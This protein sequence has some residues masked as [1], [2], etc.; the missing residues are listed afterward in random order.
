[1]FR[2]AEIIWTSFKMA[3]QE[4]RSN[5]LRTFLSL[6]GIT[7]GIFCII[8][9]LSTI[10]SMQSAV[11]RDLSS[12][13]SQTIFVDKWQIGLG[14]DYP[15]WKYIKRPVPKYDELK[16]LKLKVPEAPHIAYFTSINANVDYEE[17]T[18]TGVNYYGCSEDFNKIQTIEIAQGRYFEQSEFDHG[19]PVIVM[20]Y[21]IAEKL[22]GKPENCIGVQVRLKGGKTATIIGMIKKQGQ[23]M[24]GGWDYDNCVMLPH[25]FMK[26]IVR[27]DYAS[28]VMLVEAG[29]G[30]SKEA[31]KD[32]LEGAMRSIRKLSPMQEDNFALNDIDTLTKFLEPIFRGM[33]IGG[34]VIAAL[35]L[36]VGMFGVANIM[37]VTVRERTSQ[38]GLKKAIGAKRGV[39][40]TEFLLESAFLCIIGGIFGLAAVFVLT[41][42]ISTSI[43]F[44]VT[45]PAHIILLAV[46]ICIGTGVIAGIIPAFIAARMDPVVAIRTK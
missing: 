33:N 18:L 6:L 41:L 29:K 44:P 3:L 7:F 4:F 19:T 16:A 9:V 42:I 34:W 45:I 31:L 1:M 46:S 27:D 22:F 37:F 40:L 10:S 26:A 38:I 23:S 25:E 21:T 39:I 24:I 32:E 5:K 13:G 17:N 11:T 20:G 15:W 14:A 30:M 8:S 35:S 2:Y 43:G 12:L 36:L 28:P